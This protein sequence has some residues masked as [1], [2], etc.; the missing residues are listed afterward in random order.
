[1]YE[2]NL[3]ASQHTGDV[4][5]TSSVERFQ[6]TPKDL[7]LAVFVKK[8]FIEVAPLVQ[9]SEIRRSRSEPQ[10]TETLTRLEVPENEI[11]S[12]SV[13][14]NLRIIWQAHCANACKPCIFIYRKGDGC[15]KGNLCSHCHFCLKRLSEDE[16][17]YVR[18]VDRQPRLVSD[19]F[20]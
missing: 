6:A 1:M 5:R 2:L 19:C 7:D 15:R 9:G 14:E 20:L 4:L 13:D 11:E 18:S 16:I 10:L 17:G 12:D 8:T 3:F